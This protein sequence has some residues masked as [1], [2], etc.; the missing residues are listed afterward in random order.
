MRRSPTA[1]LLVDVI[2]PMNFAGADALLG[3]AIPAADRIARL[4]VRAREAGIAVVYVND[5]FD[6]WHLGFRELVESFLTAD[7]PGKPIIERLAPELAQEFYV[8]KP[9][10]SGFFRTGLEELLRRLDARK[11]ILT[12]FAGDI[13]VL[14]T[15]NDAYMRGFDVVIPSDCVASERDEDNAHALRQ[16]A[17]ILKA[18]VSPS[19][20]IRFRPLQS[21]RE[22]RRVG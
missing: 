17:R 6:C 10:H 13:C 21:E 1:L 3:H 14:F 18:D 19:D 9:G 20:T 22:D 4:R 11:L 8:L 5:N 15:A 7:V 12:G 16:M 2:N